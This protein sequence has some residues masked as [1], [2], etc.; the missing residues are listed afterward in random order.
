[1]DNDTNKK[2]CARCSKKDCAQ[3]VEENGKSFCCQTCCGEYKKEKGEKSA[4][5][6]SASGG[7]EEPVNVCR[8]C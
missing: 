4:R 8:F 2:T 6:G 3:C 7:K 1:M 5:G